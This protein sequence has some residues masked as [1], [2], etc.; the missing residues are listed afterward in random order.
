MAL[1][2]SKTNE[3]EFFQRNPGLGKYT[4]FDKSKPLIKKFFTYIYGDN[5]KFK[6]QEN[7]CLKA[8]FF[9]ESCTYKNYDL[10]DR[11]DG[12]CLLWVLWYLEL[13]LKNQALSRNQVL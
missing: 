1:Y 6:F 7:F 3:I 9:S 11:V 4:V 2:D 8:D 13:R 10:Y 12:D 5:L